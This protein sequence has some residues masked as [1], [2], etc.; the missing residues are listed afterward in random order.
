MYIYILY[1]YI[2]YIYISIYT[3]T[4][5]TYIYIHN[6]FINNSYVNIYIYICIY[7]YTHT[8]THS[9]F[10]PKFIWECLRRR[11]LVDAPAFLIEQVKTLGHLYF[12]TG[13]GSHSPLPQGSHSPLPHKGSHSRLPHY[14]SHWLCHS[15][16]WCKIW[17]QGTCGGDW[18]TFRGDLWHT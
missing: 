6:I 2:V 4:Q 12:E 17:G 10:I 9:L 8:H 7:T 13:R 14:P 5:Y 3:H 18:G 11:V 1:I 16:I 15:T